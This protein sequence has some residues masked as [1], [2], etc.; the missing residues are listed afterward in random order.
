[1]GATPTEAAGVGIDPRAIVAI[2]AHETMLETYGPAA[3]IHNPFG[4]GPGSAFAS[5]PEDGK[6][7]FLCKRR[8]GADRFR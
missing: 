4:L 1:M 6:P 3:E 7:R 5:E 2:A 8:E